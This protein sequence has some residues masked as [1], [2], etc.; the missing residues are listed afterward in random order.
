[1]TNPTPDHIMDVAIGYGV[2]K[3]LLTAVGMGL[4]TRLAQAPMT[5]DQ[6]AAEYDLA[7][8]PA[9]DMLDMLVSVDLLDRQGQ[10]DSA[11]YT[12]TP[13]T[14]KYLDKASP[15][16]M[17]GIIELWDMRNYRY[18]ADIKTSLQTARPVSETRENDE[19]FFKT[20]YSDPARLE[21]FMDA[22]AGSSIRNFQKL[23][24]VFPFSDYRTMTDIGGADALLS[25]TIAPAHPDL[26][27]KT[28]DLPMVTEIAR[29]KIAAAGLEN[30]IEATTG[31]FFAEPLPPADIITMGMI[32]HD[33]NM[34]RKQ[35]LIAKAYDALP[36]G[37]AFIAIEAIID[38]DRRT[39]TYGLFMSLSMAMEFGN[40]FDFTFAEFCDWCAQAGFRKFEC[41]P[42]AG[43]SS[44]A[45][46]WK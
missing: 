42:L 24:Q 33:W 39:N 7:H 18:W 34:E 2:S 5:L 4:Y 30:Q 40:A 44:A 1:M 38:D 14:A 20:L 28:V 43:P 41:L 23:A 17:G 35:Q 25:R 10:G 36:D 37:G 22:M 8:R 29:R 15:D 26:K 19:D 3:M 13:A 46:A 16:Y 11:H 9:M 6:I 31:D 27:I 32:L 21:A 12:N 45:I